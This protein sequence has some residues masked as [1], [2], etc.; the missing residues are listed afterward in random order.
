MSAKIKVGDRAPTFRLPDQEGNEVDLAE[1]IERGPVVLYFYPKD[2]TAG[3]TME[4]RE[5]RVMHEEFQRRGAD[6]IGVSSD[7]VET[8]HRFAEDHEL[9]FTLL[10]DVDDEARDM[11]GARTALGMPDRTT[12]LID[13]QGIV[14]MVF[15]SQMQPRKHAPEALKVLDE[16]S[17]E[18]TVTSAKSS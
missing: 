5:F 3:C 1:R 4:A 6:V 17:A 15:S 14:R 8:H 18:R 9:P 11:Y 10:S 13:R 7:D 2:F 12:Y 16:V